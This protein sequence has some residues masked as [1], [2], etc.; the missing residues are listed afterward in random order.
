MTPPHTTAILTLPL[1]DALP[2]YPSRYGVAE[3]DDEG[4]VLSLE[5]KPKIPKS[6][7]A[8]TGLYFYDR[9]VVDIAASIDR[10]STRLNSSH[11]CISYAV[12]CFKK[13]IHRK[14]DIQ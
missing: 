6:R 2:I 4:K 14:P 5:E 1:H 3:M 12:F 10:K 8:V 11:R 7:Y 13:K 9:E